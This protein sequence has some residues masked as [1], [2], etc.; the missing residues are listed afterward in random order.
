LMLGW[1]QA[2]TK[3]PLGGKAGKFSG[4]SRYSMKLQFSYGVSGGCLSG[5]Q[6]VRGIAS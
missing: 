3:R 6:T 4:I 2:V 1:K 5:Q